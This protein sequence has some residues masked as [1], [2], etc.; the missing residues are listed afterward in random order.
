MSKCAQLIFFFVLGIKFFKNAAPLIVEAF[1]F[2]ST[3]LRSAIIDLVSSTN[4][5]Q[6]GYSHVFSFS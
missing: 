4:S 6:I 1:T 2:G 3:F 5:S